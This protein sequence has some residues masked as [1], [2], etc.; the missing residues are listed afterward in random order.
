M[1]EKMYFRTERYVCAQP[2]SLCRGSAVSMDLSFFTNLENI[3]MTPSLV[4][5]YFRQASHALCLC[6]LYSREDILLGVYS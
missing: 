1:K 4:P 2:V 3:R 6:I 5:I